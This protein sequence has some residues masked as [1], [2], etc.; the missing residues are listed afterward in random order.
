MTEWRV[1]LRMT[2]NQGTEKLLTS[3]GLC[4]RAGRTVIG[5]PQ[6]IDAMR[7]GGKNAPVLVLEAADTS[8]N[9]HKRLTDKCSYYKTRHVRLDCSG[10]RL[11]AAVGKSASLAAVA[12]TDAGICRA[13]EKYLT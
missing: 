3:L 1:S 7:K 6:I 12:V 13:V 8:E 4:A 2:E 10:E 9:T 5:A 11:A